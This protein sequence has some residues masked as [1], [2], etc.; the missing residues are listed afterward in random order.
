MLLTVS[1]STSTTKSPRPTTPQLVVTTNWSEDPIPEIQC[2]P[3]PRPE[4]IH[5]PCPTLVPP[6]WIAKYRVEVVTTDAYL[7]G[8]DDPV[9]IDIIGRHGQESVSR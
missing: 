3:C 6:P 2:P 5:Q 1:N 7:A 8:T 4:I 9:F